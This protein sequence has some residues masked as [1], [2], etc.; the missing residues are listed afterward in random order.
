MCGRFSL[1]ISGDEISKYFQVSQVQDWKPRYNIAPSQEIVTIVQTLLGQRQLKGMKWGLI[2]SWS[3]DGKIASKLINARG[4]TVAEKPS[5][6]N[7]FKHRRCLIMADGF[8]EWQNTR[9]SKQPYYIH[10]KNRHPFALAG[11]WEVSNSGQTEEVLSCCIITTEAN[12]LMKP[13]HHRMPVI[14]SGDAYSQWLD[15][16]VFDREIL[17]SFLTSYGSDAMSAYQVS[18]KVNRPTNDNPDCLEPIVN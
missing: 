7:A 9:N 17:E 16:N 8:Y 4:E 5:F 13:L 6:R 1:T 10:L 14:L 12:E 15:H 11:L 3:K 2:P 18:Q